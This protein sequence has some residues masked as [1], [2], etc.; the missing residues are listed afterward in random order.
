MELNCPTPAQIPELHALWE[1]VFGPCDGFWNLFLQTGF[2][3]ERCRC[4]LRE[5]RIAASLCWFDVFCDGK[6]M[7]YLYAV[8]THPAHHHQGLCRS[9][10]SAVHTQLTRLGYHACLLVPADPDLRQMYRSL[11]YTDA[12]AVSEFSCISGPAPVFLRE[13]SLSEY[14]RLRRRLL[15]TGGVLQEQ[16]SLAFLAAQARLFAGEELLLAA[17]EED[18]I[19]HALELLGSPEAA[20]GILNALDC[21]RGHF[22]TPGDTLPFAMWHPLT[23]DAP[24]PQYFGFAFD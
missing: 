4:I 13:V 3:P 14:A 11:G 16:E 7:A 24:K 23:P 5:G 12:T 2:S 21:A 15:P 1:T 22:R 18:G 17:Y 8:M 9:L 20:P 6:K 19:L 10:L